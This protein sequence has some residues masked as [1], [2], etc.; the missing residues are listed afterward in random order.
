MDIRDDFETTQN[1][2]SEIYLMT[3]MNMTKCNDSEKVIE[4]EWPVG[5]QTR[6]DEP[7]LIRPQIDLI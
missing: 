2:W 4:I 3:L 5:F 6:S 1:T 7:K